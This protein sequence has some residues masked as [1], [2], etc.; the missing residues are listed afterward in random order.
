MDCFTYMTIVQEDASVLEV[1]LWGI[2]LTIVGLIDDICPVVV[3]IATN[4]EGEFS[5][6]V[7]LS[8]QHIDDSIATLL[9]W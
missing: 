4:S 9:T 1:V 5:T 7:I 8:I 3:A 6:R 2:E